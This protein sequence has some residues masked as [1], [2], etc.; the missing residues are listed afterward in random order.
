[1]AFVDLGANEGFF[2]VI[3][4]RLV[5]SNGRVLAIEP[6]A[7]LAPVIQRNLV[8]NEV[9]NT[10][11]LQAA[12][13]D[14]NGI[15]E[16]NLAPEQAN[17]GSSGLSRATRYANPTQPVRLMTLEAWLARKRPDFSRCHENRCRR[18]RI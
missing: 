9:T 1:M 6:Q 15:A 2:T 11:L 17:S 4:S 16:S 10:T 3:A 18:L 8:L 5:A 14:A 7:R 12:V 13:P